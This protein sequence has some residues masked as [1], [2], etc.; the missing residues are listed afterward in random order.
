MIAILE[1]KKTGQVNIVAQVVSYGEMFNPYAKKW[2]H[3]LEL[4]NGNNVLTDSNEN[5]IRI[6]ESFKGEC[7]CLEQR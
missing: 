3:C 7:K 5:R 6:Q 4:S 2:F 1:N